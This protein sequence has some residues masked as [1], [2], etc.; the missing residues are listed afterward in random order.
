MSGSL[1]RRFRLS[2]LGALALALTIP[3][4]LTPLAFAAEGPGRPDSADTRVSKVEPFKGQGAKA[5]RDRVA[6]DRAVNRKI[7]EQA[8]QERAAAWPKAAL[9]RGDLESPPKRPPFIDV[10]AAPTGGKNSGSATADGRTEVKVLDQRAADRAGIT[11]VLFTVGADHP[12]NARLTVDYRA[13]ASALGGGWATRLGLVSLPP[14][15]LTTPGRPECRVTTPVESRNDPVAERVTAETAVGSPGTGS[16]G[17]G[18]R[19]MAL[20]A[21]SAVGPAA[22]G[23]DFKASPLSPAATWTAGGSAGSFTWSHPVT[24]PPVAAGPVPSLALSYDSGSTDGRTANTNNQGTQIGEGFDLTSS[25]V[26]RRYGSCDDDG[27]TDKNDLCWKYENASLVLNGKAT[28]LVKN[29]ADGKWRLKNDDASKVVHHKGADNGDEGDSGDQGEHWTVTTGNGTTYTFG[30]NKLTGAGTERTNSVWTVPVFGDDSGEPGH[31]KGNAFAD[32]SHQQAWRWNLDLVEDVHGNASTYWYKAETNHYARNGD[33]TGLASYTRGGY[34]DEIRYGQRASALF[35]GLTSA[36]VTFDY[37]ERCF[38]TD[39]TSLTKDTADNWPDV[40]FDAICSASETDC[41]ATGPAFFTRK[42]LTGINT[43]VWYAAAEPDAFTDVDSYEFQQEFFDG[44]DIGNSSDQTLVLQKLTRTGKNGTPVTLPGADFTYQQRPN[45]VAGGTWPGNANVLPLT[46]PRISTLTSETGAITTVAFSSPECVRG[47]SMPAAEDSNN[48]SCYPVKWAV[49]GGDV[50][51]DWFHKYR[52]I[53][54]NVSDPTGGNP[55]VE[56]TYEYSGPGWAHNDDPLTLNKHRTWSEW[57]GYQKVTAYTGPAGAPRTKAMTVYMQGMNGDKRKNGTTRDAAVQGIDLDNDPSETT[58]NLTVANLNDDQQLAGQVRQQITYNGATAIS[59]TVNNYWSKETAS[60]QKSYANTRAHYVRPAGSRTYTYL[61]TA[62]KWRSAADSTTYDNTYG[63]ATHAEFSGDTAV[64]GDETCTRTWYARNETA[65]LTDL[66]SRTRTVKGDCSRTDNTLSLPTATATR[67]DILT[68]TATVYDTPDATGWTAGQTPTLGLPTWTGRAKSYP[69]ASGT[70]DRDPAAATGWQTVSRTTYDTATAKLGRPLT[71]TDAKGHVTSTAYYPAT[72]GPVT[73][74]IITQP[75]LTSNNQ[76][77]KTYTYYDIARGSVTYTLDANLKRT[78]HTYDALGRI[79][80]TWLPNRS[81][82]GGATPNAKYAYSFTR[83]VAPWASTSTLKADGTTYA[84]SY[85][86]HD[87]QLRPLQTQTPGAVG[88]RI[89]T[90]TRYD[91]RGLAYETQ[92]DAFDSTKEPEGAYYRVAYS[93][94][95][96][97]TETVFDGAGR[98]VKST[99]SSWGVK[100]WDTTT[101]YTGDSTA[102]SAT[103]GGNATRTITDT[104][105]RTTETRT[106]AGTQPHDTQYGAGTGTSYTRVAHTHTADGKQATITGPDDAVWSYTYDLFGRQNSATDPDTGTS[107]TAYTDLDQI[108]STK[109]AEG[110]ILLYGY[111]EASRKT[112]L[113]Q[114]SRTD[115]NKLAAWTYDSLV[116]GMADASIRYEGGTTGKAYTRAVTAYDTLSRPTTTTL[117]LP[118]TDPLVTSNAVPATITSGVSYRLDGTVNTTKE[119]AAAG[120][121]AESVETRYNNAG[122]PIEQSGTNNYLL[123]VDYSALGQLHQV[124]LGTS[125]AAGNKNVFISNTFEDGTGRILTSS[126]DDMTRG[127]VQ[128]L[129]YTYDQAGNVTSIFDQANLGSGTDNQCFTYDGHRRLT[130][131]WTPQTPNC[132]TTNRTT[133]GPAPYWTSYTYTESGQRKTEKQHTGT[134]RTTTYCY[135]PARPHSLSSTTTGTS[136]TGVT[137]QYTYDKAGNT[138]T[139]VDKT[140]GT[141]AQNLTWNPEGKLAR[142]AQ[143]STS[144]NYLY[145]ASGELLIRRNN[146][147]GGE[148]VLYLGNTEVHLTAAKKWAVRYYN[149]AGTTLAVRSNE[150]GSDKLSFLA[151]DHHNT[152][153]I[154]ITADSTQTLSKRYTTPFGRERGNPMGPWPDDK[155]FLGKPEDDATGLTHIGAR[156]YDSSTGQ[157]ISVDPLLMPEQH[158]SLN[159]Y[160]YANNTPVSMSDPTGLYAAWCVTTQCI[161]QTGGYGT[162]PTLSTKQIAIEDGSAQRHRQ[163]TYQSYRAKDY[164]CGYYG[165]TNRIAQAK[166]YVAPK[167]YIAPGATRRQIEKAQDNQPWY[168]T[169]VIGFAVEVAVPD[170]EA[171]KG[172]ASDFGFNG[173]CG[174][175]L[176][177]VPIFKGGKVIKVGA[178]KFRPDC[179]CFLAGT[180]VLLADGSTKAIEDIEV[181]DKVLAT[182]PETDE[183]A[184]KE[185]TALIRTDDDTNYND[186]SIATEDGVQKLTATHEHPFWSPSEN[187]W[188]E[189]THLKPGMTLRTDDGDTAIVTGNRAYTQNARTY[190]L[191]VEDL[192]TYYVLAGETPVLVHNSNCPTASKYED[193]TSPGARML[194]KSTDV[195]PV[196]FGKNLETNGWARTDKGPNIM[197]EKDGARYF[198]R[199]KANSHEGWTADYYNPGSK[200][201]D[202]KIRLGED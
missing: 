123:G 135:N 171:I 197:Y 180:L 34:L 159:G 16:P 81:K 54:V 61:T 156:Q 100:K 88:G 106:Y 78:E 65:G 69:A 195:G 68:D 200:K 193:I 134:P 198:L 189:A 99:F 25:Y 20:T 83:T 114:T 117:T 112:G 107:T 24:V 40:P 170:F 97:Q 129:A 158:Q 28:E 188:L 29:D 146:A 47:S 165:C 98:P 183:T 178:K 2:A 132:A 44:Q 19:V 181:G 41:K 167:P 191:T 202:I 119:P 91:E 57:R 157:F 72:G 52:V 86:I 89:L 118:T 80:A 31:G 43:H 84:T 9:I 3:T 35:S 184:A 116:K 93:Q 46:R 179:E 174:S 45:R 85:T 164:P 177:E 37:K 196:D 186:L 73:G 92:S 140:G 152:S 5:A 74:I 126:T 11:G 150:T 64:T 10:G 87:S 32:R 13:F 155:G 90:D 82:S 33:K 142:L 49:N 154:S 175:A 162:S 121:P 75:K 7:T 161:E 51:L 108:D 173:D 66:V 148:T 8:Q 50:A 141:T 18:P 143:A 76:T 124:R 185:V 182:D 56:H 151:A 62:K 23:G 12:G 138:V 58:D 63:M 133:A 59:S 110:R 14:C 48:T 36:K 190:N 201:A 53:A 60:Q 55:S 39:C 120:L 4:T 115:A 127:P 102:V 149:A 172:C 94:S 139:R 22:G 77:H 137:P 160:S 136:C 144:T 21:A 199:G 166:P 96:S 192:H 153:T 145:D 125:T 30:L 15:A 130:E 128:D 103:E 168:K 17:R 95:P 79:T 131:A 163:A 6:R 111:D 109:D 104:L 194:N 70:Q 113:W 176:L 26:E 67:G 105:G 169:G 187:T 27:N 147:A 38:A 42:R 101:S 1:L 71:V 122:L